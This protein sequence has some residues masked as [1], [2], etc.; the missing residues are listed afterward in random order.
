VLPSSGFERARRHP[1]DEGGIDLRS[2]I[3]AIAALTTL[4]LAIG[5]ITAPAVATPVTDKLAQARVI[6]AQIDV[7]S[8]KAEIA[9]EDWNNAKIA[10][11][12]LHAKVVKVESDM[13]RIDAQTGVLEGSLAARADSMYRSGPLGILDVLLGTSS[14]ED[15]AATWDFLTD[16]NRQESE[17]VAS[18]KA[19]RVEKVA[20]EA[21]LKVAQ[22]QAK[23]V[24]DTMAARRADV[25]AAEAK[26]KS[27]LK[28]VEAQI[29]VLRAADRARRAAD[30]RRHHGGGGGTGWNWGNPPHAP[31]SGVVQIALKY[32]GRPY[33]WAASGPYAFDCSGFTMFVY[34]QVG[35]RLPH[36]SR[37]QI[38]C[39]A[40]VD[41]ANLQPGDLL[42][43]YSPIHHVAIYIGGGK[44]VHAPHTGDVVSIDPVYWGDFAGACRP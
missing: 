43:F 5:L 24:Y 15:F 4:S 17:T 2:S 16:Q 1:T 42:F 29:A 38:N 44:M 33:Q 20:A 12:A 36:S 19:L 31:R 7:L 11:D 32:L 37:A 18:L 23:Q 22:T 34:A 26:A 21:D 8:T 6:Q 27:L 3:R 13:A 30:A 28:G 14:F 41:R 9:A 10:Y 39:G 25:L 35:V 40:R